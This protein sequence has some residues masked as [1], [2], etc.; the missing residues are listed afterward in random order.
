MPAYRRHFFLRRQTE[1]S[2]K[3]T[4]AATAN[5]S[6]RQGFEAARC[7]S[8]RHPA[9][10]RGAVWLLRPQAG[11]D[12]LPAAARMNAAQIVFSWDILGGWRP[13]LLA[14]RSSW[15]MIFWWLGRRG[16]GGFG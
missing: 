11:I 10:F 7:V 9:R 6:C 8:S 13:G 12:A 15:S 1:H 14:Q 5:C 2:S 3:L 16:L 4:R